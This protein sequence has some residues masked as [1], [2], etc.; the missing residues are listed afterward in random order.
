[1]KNI[2]SDGTYLAKNP[3]WHEEDAPFKARHIANILKR[4]KVRYSRVAEIGCGTGG[5]LRNL[6]KLTGRSDATWQGFDI[7]SEAL[8]LAECHPEKQDIIFRKEDLLV[9]DVYF[10]VLLVIDVFEHVPDYLGFLSQCKTRAR[11]KIYHIPL[12]LHL[13]SVFRDSLGEARKLLGHLHYFSEGS[14]IATL[15]D[16]GHTIVDRSLTAGAVDLFWHHP[17]FRRAL[18]N[19]PRIATGLISQSY[20]ARLFGGYSLLVLTE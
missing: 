3:T 14:A 2:Y 11:Y 12:D 8:S 5:V 1:M 18:A 7:S 10:D 9:T 19:I 20:S 6:R 16:T 4:N 17:S 13:L 15:V